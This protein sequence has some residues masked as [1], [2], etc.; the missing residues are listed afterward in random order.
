[1]KHT[2]FA[3]L[4]FIAP[5]SLLAEQSAISSSGDV[6]V[7]LEVYKNMLEQLRDKP[8]AAPASY[9]IGD[10]KIL[11]NIIDYE[12]HT[13]ANISVTLTVKTFEKKW[14]LVPILPYGAALSKVTVNGVPAQ[15]VQGVEWLSWSTQKAG[16]FKIELHYNIDAQRSESGFVLPLPIPRAAATK[17]TVKYPGKNQDMAIIPSSDLRTTKNA[18]TTTTTAS[19]ATSSSI[20]ISWRIPSKQ[21]YIMSRAI[22]K[23][24]LRGDAIVWKANYNVEVFTGESV[25]L[26]LMPSSITLNDVLINKKSATIKEKDGQFVAILHGRG[27]YNVQVEFQVPIV[28]DQGPPKVS[29]SLLRVPIS[30]FELT[31]PGKKD[32]KVIPKTNVLSTFKKNKTISTVYSPLS[33]QITFTWIDAIPEDQKTKM[34]ANA[35][36]YHSLYAEEGVLHGRAIID[37]DVTHG[38]T[39]ALAFHIPVGVQVNRINSTTGGISD[40]IVTNNKKAKNKLITVYLDRAIKGKFVLEVL[41]EQLIEK[42]ETEISIEVPLLTAINMHRQRG[43]IALLVGPELSLKPLEE[44]NVTKVGENQLPALFVM[45]F[46]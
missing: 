38:E 10:S 29:I 44:K 46:R 20:L 34:R 22:Y 11:V 8:K 3:M 18:T 28:K 26:K 45:R 4:L 42:V 5:F 40:W 31:L 25:N 39:N 43:M 35:N 16:V 7:P 27:N 24:V 6:R 30:R 23:G 1:M 2:L 37:F 9:A 41:Y 19:I 12:D 17:L 21:S 36:L 33:N 13:S 32:V 15:L 14:T